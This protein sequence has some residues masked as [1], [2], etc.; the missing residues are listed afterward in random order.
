V[1]RGLLTLLGC[2]AL[3]A[4]CTPAVE[5]FDPGSGTTSEAPSAATGT[6]VP[7]PPSDDTSTGPT[8]EDTLDDSPVD[9]SSTSEGFDTACFICC[10]ETGELTPPC[11]PW[12]QDC[13]PGEKCAWW[14]ND[15]GTLWN[16]TRCVPLDPDPAPRDAPCEVQGSG[17]SGVDSCEAENVCFWVDPDSL[18]GTCVALCDPSEESS[19]C[20]EGTQ[21]HQWYEDSLAVCIPSCDPVRGACSPTNGACVP[22]NNGF[23]CWPTYGPY[24]PE[25]GALCELQ[26]CEAGHSCV[27]ASLVVG[28][29]HDRCCAAYCDLDAPTCPEGTACIPYFGDDPA[30]ADYAHIGVCGPPP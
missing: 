27:D 5:T 28:C 25:P 23:S 24:I 21:C 15:G 8:P 30:P 26:N 4:G 9:H 10:D 3:V 12:G 1:K 14:A 13:D 20:P 19:S 18:E 17:V 6:T 7:T 2:S 22:T 29:E 11:D 16:Y